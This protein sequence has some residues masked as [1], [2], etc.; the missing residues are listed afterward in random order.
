MQRKGWWRQRRTNDAP[1]TRQSYG[2]DR[3][4]LAKRLLHTTSDV[5]WYPDLLDNTTASAS[6]R[7]HLKR[8]CP[9]CGGLAMRGDTMCYTCASRWRTSPP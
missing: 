8:R 2:P 3:Q 1:E 7:T 5:P 6:Q 4:A 9:Y